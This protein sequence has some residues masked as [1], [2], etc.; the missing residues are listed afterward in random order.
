MKKRTA[1]VISSL[2]IVAFMVSLSACSIGKI[3]NGEIVAVFKYGDASIEEPLSAADRE[4]VKEIFEG[5]SLSL[6]SSSCGFNE[7]VA[8]LIDG[9]PYCIACDMC[10]V[11][12]VK[13]QY[14]HFLLSDE[15][16]ETLRNLLITY[17]FHFPCD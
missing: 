8:L 15:E 16:N 6:G 5:K 3:G 4:T 12:Y 2:L 17:G 10:G 11:I 1:R 13:N 14:Q 9:N 7:D